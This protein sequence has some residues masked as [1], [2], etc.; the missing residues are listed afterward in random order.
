MDI[1]AL[2]EIKELASKALNGRQKLERLHAAHGERLKEGMTRARSTTYH[3]TC[4]NL[5]TDIVTP[6]EHQIKEIVRKWAAPQK[7]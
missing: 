1:Q 7:Q 4:T 2:K 6:A 3:A 5:M